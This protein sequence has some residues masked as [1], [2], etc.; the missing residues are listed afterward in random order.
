MLT[1]RAVSYLKPLIYNESAERRA[2]LIPFG[3]IYW[4]DE[5]PDF[6]A[7]MEIPEYDRAG[8]IKLFY[9]RF[10]I[11]NEEELSNDEQKFWED[12]KKR[13]SEYALFQ[14]L[15]LTKE[16]RQIQEETER[17][18]EELFNAFTDGAEDVKISEKDGVVSFSITHDLTKEDHAGI[19]RRP[20][21][22]RVFRL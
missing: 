2:S 1:D 16:D 7:F 18:A 9:I 12:A 22:K 6:H 14:R 21:W 20:W 5:I 15:E 11:W 13:V 8:I 4:E 10:K 17:G 3:G 19:T